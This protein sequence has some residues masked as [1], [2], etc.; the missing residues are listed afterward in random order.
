ME[1]VRLWNIKIGGFF[2]FC[3]AK[4]EFFLFIERFKTLMTLN[5]D[6]VAYFRLHTIQQAI[7][8]QKLAAQNLREKISVG[9]YTANGSQENTVL[10]R[11]L[12]KTHPKVPERQELLRV[13]KEV[14]L[15]RFRVSML[16]HEKSRKQ[17][18]LQ[19]L[20]KTK[21]ALVETNQ[22]RGSISNFK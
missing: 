8:K 14:E 5:I 4:A 16:N 9:G 7:K 20:E 3:Q 21:S 17:A 13:K 22:D 11:L 1:L 19:Q 18:E 2:L 10:R 6:P 12:N 15:V